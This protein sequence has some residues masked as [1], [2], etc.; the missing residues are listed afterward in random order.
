MTLLAPPRLRPTCP[1]PKLPVG[2][3]EPLPRHR[4]H[5]DL[6]ARRQ[7]AVHVH[8][9]FKDEMRLWAPLSAQPI[10]CQTRHG[11]QSERM[12][13]LV[14]PIYPTY[15]PGGRPGEAATGQ[16]GGPLDAVEEGPGGTTK[17]PPG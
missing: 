5:R 14:I 4:L 13:G 12:E 10:A 1:I 15:C 9:F 8:L 16:L 7:V 2:A 11:T 3:A 17:L 6:L